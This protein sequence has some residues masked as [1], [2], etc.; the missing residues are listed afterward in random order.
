MK[1]DLPALGRPSSPTS[2]STRSS[3][4]SS[5]LSPGSPRVNCRGARLV[6]DLKCRLPRP[7]CPPLPACTWIFAS[8]MNFINEK[9]PPAPAGLFAESGE[10]LCREHAHGF[11]VARA[12]DR[13]LD[14]ARDA[15][16]QGVVA[17]HADVVAR[18]HH[19]AALAHQ[20]LPCIGA[21]AAVG[22]DAEPLR[23]GVAPVARAAACFLVGH[24]LFP[25]GQAPTISS[26]RTSVKDWRCPCVLA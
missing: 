12:L 19:G 22:L 23:V 16:E 3:S 6:L 15:R 1:V 17:A 10:G 24:G 20:D 8:S 4:A 9:A 14:L 18:V 5:R 11:L 2:A 25:G 13:V 7:P 26:M 21:L